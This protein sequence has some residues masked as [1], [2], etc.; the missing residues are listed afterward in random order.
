MRND[1]E[2]VDGVN[3]LR[4]LVAN[5]DETAWQIGVVALRLVPMARPGEDE[6]GVRAQ[7]EQLAA[8]LGYALARLVRRRYVA[9][10]FS[11]I[12]DVPR[13]VS[14]S[15]LRELADR[16]GAGHRPDARRFVR[17][18][19]KEAR[20]SGKRVTVAE[21]LAAYD[22]LTETPPSTPAEDAT[23]DDH[24]RDLS[25]NGSSPRDT[26]TNA[27]AANNEGSTAGSPNATPA[28]RTRAPADRLRRLKDT[29][30]SAVDQLAKIDDGIS[31]EDRT[32][33]YANL[34]ASLDR[35][36]LLVKHEEGDQGDTIAA[37]ALRVTEGSGDTQSK[38]E[39]FVP[40]SH[41][42]LINGAGGS[43]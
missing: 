17:A 22:A 34:K 40:P 16:F 27:P 35:V 12:R 2:W 32:V 13:L 29:I 39:P 24:E 4:Q 5:E 6:H 3:Y 43:R 31:S 14:Y 11:G 37:G 21:A 33:L 42:A 38:D 26:Q 18:L 36:D 19:V 30:T 20:Q 15:A 41:R 1:K 23:P 10:F 25:A 9:S 7:L 8:E 28:R